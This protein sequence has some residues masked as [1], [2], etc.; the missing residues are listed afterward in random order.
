MSSITL[1]DPTQ[2][3]QEIEND[4][5]DFLKFISSRCF[6]EPDPPANFSAIKASST[7]LNV[8]WVA[9]PL[10]KMNG[11]SEGYELGYKRADQQK[12]TSFRI[13]DHWVTTFNISGLDEYIDY[14]LRIRSKNSRMWGDIKELKVPVRTDQD[15]KKFSLLFSL[16]SLSSLCISM[17]MV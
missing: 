8:S 14:D 13:R 3:D 17:R 16:H 9:V 12:W 7:R 6:V 1:F 4:S 15:G 5:L 2:K 11:N 10:V